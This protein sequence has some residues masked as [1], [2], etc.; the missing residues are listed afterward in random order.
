[1]PD[2]PTAVPVFALV[3]ETPYNE[4]VVPLVCEVQF[5]PPLV[6]LRI[7]PNVPTVVPLFASVKETP[8]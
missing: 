5:V 8:Y 6:V 3:K 7:V 1:M 4:I 2:E